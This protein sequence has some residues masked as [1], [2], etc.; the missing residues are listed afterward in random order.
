MLRQANA[1]AIE[2]DDGSGE[3]T[4]FSAREAWGGYIQLGQMLTDELELSARLG[5]LNPLRD[6]DPKLSLTQELGGGVSYYFEEHNLKVQSDY[7]YYA[8]NSDFEAG[9]HQVRIQSQLFF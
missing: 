7:F 1:R 8:R 2:I 4:S 5:H 6:T 9:D 3:T